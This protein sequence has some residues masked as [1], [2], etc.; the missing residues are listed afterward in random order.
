M[1]PES[2]QQ[3]AWNGPSGQGNNV[4]IWLDRHSKDI[5]D[6]V[7]GCCKLVLVFLAIIF[8]IILII[9]LSL[10]ILMGEEL[11]WN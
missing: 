1:V 5:F 2:Q 8:L 4:R 11:N 10:F 9:Y 7:Y 3:M 6:K